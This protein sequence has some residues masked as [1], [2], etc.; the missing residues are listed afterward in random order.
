MEV[1]L[2]QDGLW[3]LGLASTILLMLLTGPPI[4]LR[5]AVYHVRRRHDWEVLVYSGDEPSYRPGL[6]ALVELLPTKAAAAAR[7]EDLWTH[8]SDHDRLPTR[9]AS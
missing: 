2:W 4:F 6:A 5:W 7:A 8:L 1:D 3:I 9:T